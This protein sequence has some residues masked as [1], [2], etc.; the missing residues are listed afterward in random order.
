MEG[1]E[2]EIENWS[3]KIAGDLQLV[4]MVDE[5]RE[6]KLSCFLA[7]ALRCGVVDL[8]AIFVHGQSRG[9]RQVGS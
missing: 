6:I 9:V 5:G 1:G 3:G 7:M 4:R 2:R 8:A